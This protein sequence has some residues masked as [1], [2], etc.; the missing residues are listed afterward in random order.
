VYLLVTG[1]V[2]LLLRK[3]SFIRGGKVIMVDLVS[4]HILPMHYVLLMAIFYRCSSNMA[5]VV[6]NLWSF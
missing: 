3:G 6:L 5:R 2:L 4:I 1:T